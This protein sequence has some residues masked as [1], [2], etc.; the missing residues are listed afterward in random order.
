MNDRRTSRKELAKKN[1][2]QQQKRKM[3]LALI[4]VILTAVLVYATGIYGASL[5]YFGDFISSGMVL[6]QF[7]EGWPVETDLS[8]LLQ[9]QE[10]G[11]SLCTLDQD[12]L[13]IY[14]PTAKRVLY[15]QHAMQSPAMDTSANRVLVYNT[16]QTSLKIANSHKILFSQEMDNTIIHGDI[17]SSNHIALTTKSAS[18]NGQVTVFDYKMDQLFTWY[19]AKNFPV[20]SC[21]SDNGKILAVATVQ[22][23]NGK[24]VSDIYI[25][26]V[27]KG[28]EIFTIHKDGE[29]PL[30]TIFLSQNKLLIAY[31]T[32]LELWDLQKA[33]KQAAY[34]YNSDR[35]LSVDYQQ[36]YIALALGGYTK[37]EG[38]RVVL[39]SENLEEKMDEPVDDGVK[40]LVISQSRIFLLGNE[41]IYEY[42]YKGQLLSKKAVSPLTKKV[43]D[44]GQTLLISSTQM[45][46]LEKTKK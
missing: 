24:L 32:V 34:S 30:E 3:R 19:C 23:Q 7:G 18:Y 45:S 39:L 17:S 28:Q 33:E 26:N 44:F 16:G 10:M 14:S 13:S 21:L 46:Q 9:A 12:N 38:N 42:N 29:Y 25:L 37:E 36:P 43:M 8:S 20:Y 35:L 1:K 41:N 31:P 2:K 15:Y 4:G 5:A 6:F 22:T 27:A 40:N 11:K